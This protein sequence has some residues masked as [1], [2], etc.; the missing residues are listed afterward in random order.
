MGCRANLFLILKIVVF[1][2]I[3]IGIFPALKTVTFSF[4]RKSLRALSF[5]Q[6]VV[7]SPNVPQLYIFIFFLRCW[8]WFALPHSSP[9]A[10]RLPQAAGWLLACLLTKC[11]AVAADSRNHW[12]LPFISNGD[13]HFF[14]CLLIWRFCRQSNRK[15]RKDN[16]PGKLYLL[17]TPIN[18]FSGYFRLL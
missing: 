11:A 1:F 14:L 15:K 10:L 7:S 2:F 6:R 16:T 3:L 5:L 8:C 17:Y 12:F 13:G 9:F 4:E 18:Y